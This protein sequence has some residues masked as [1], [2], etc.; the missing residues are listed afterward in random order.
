MAYYIFA[1]ILLTTGRYRFQIPQIYLNQLIEEFLVF[2]VLLF[3][4]STFDLKKN[5]PAH[6]L[7]LSRIA[8]FLIGS[9]DREPKSIFLASSV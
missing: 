9:S 6:Y 2:A 7:V 3:L 5:Q 1:T 8:L 4:I